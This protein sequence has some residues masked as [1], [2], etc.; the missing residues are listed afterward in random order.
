MTLKKKINRLDKYLIYSFVFFIICPSILWFFLEPN[1]SSENIDNRNLEKFPV[2][3]GLTVKEF[4]KEFEYWYSDNLPFRTK[5]ISFYSVLQYKLTGSLESSKLFFGK[6]GWLFYSDKT[7][8]DPIADYKRINEFSPSELKII[9]ERLSIL[10]QYAKNHGA[11]FVF[12]ICP[13]KENICLEENMPSILRDN[14][15]SRTHQLVKYLRYNTNINVVFPF[16][17]LQKVKD[18][19]PIYYKIDTHWTYVGGY[20]GTRE[21]FSSLGVNTPTI[22]E[23]KITPLE[24]DS[25]D[26]ANLSGAPF[27]FKESNTFKVSDFSE[28]VPCPAGIEENRYHCD[29]KNLPFKKIVMSR[30]SFG[31]AMMLPLAVNSQDTFIA[32]RKYFKY[33]SIEKENADLFIFET[34]ERHLHKILEDDFLK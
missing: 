7:D 6:K 21:L 31:E 27:L 13:N 9:A 14:N 30:D 11:K 29:K 33:D 25:F 32:V 24:K 3:N 23:F 22:E 12:I 20:I 34:A 8:G 18:K 4:P 2:L 28:A 10:E 26:L 5:L 17:E 16:E 15:I 1:L 19:Y